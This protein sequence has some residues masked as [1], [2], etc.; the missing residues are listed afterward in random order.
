MSSNTQIRVSSKV[1]CDKAD[2][3]IQELAVLTEMATR[4]IGLYEREL[5]ERNAAMAWHV[6]TIHEY[7]E[8]TERQRR[9]AN[10][11]LGHLHEIK[12]LPPERLDETYM[13]V[14]RALE[15]GS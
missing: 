4:M 10:R 15:E 1:V 2:E 6:K 8:Q 12:A 11:L 5:A 7:S 3:L 9:R 13:I 14:D